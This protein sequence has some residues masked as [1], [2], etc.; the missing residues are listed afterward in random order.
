MVPCTQ[1]SL[2]T[3]LPVN[4]YV[5]VD[6]VGCPLHL[7]LK[8]LFA[9]HVGWSGYTTRHGRW[10]VTTT[11]LLMISASVTACRICFCYFVFS[12]T[13]SITII[14]SSM[15][16]MGSH[17]WFMVVFTTERAVNSLSA[18]F[19]LKKVLAG[20]CKRLL[21]VAWM[22]HKVRCQLGV[23]TLLQLILCGRLWVCI[24]LKIFLNV[25]CV[26]RLMHDGGIFRGQFLGMKLPWVVWCHFWCFK[27]LTV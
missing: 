3:A 24:L 25:W 12:C 13:F 14:T 6:V 17:F 22:D 26:K 11:W 8:A 15:I 27:K 20:V 10:D 2:L 19:P 16:M 7:D 21:Y 18:I 4:V 9:K 5:V 23:F 1:A